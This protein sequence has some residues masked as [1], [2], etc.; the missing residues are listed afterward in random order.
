MIIYREQC[1]HKKWDNITLYKDVE[2][3]IGYIQSS[4]VIELYEEISIN[5]NSFKC[6]YR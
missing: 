6:R 2:N 5:S 3:K 1:K 4:A